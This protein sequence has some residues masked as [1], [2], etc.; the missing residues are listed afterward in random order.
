METDRYLASYLRQV[1]FMRNLPSAY[2]LELAKICTPRH[3]AV[4]EVIIAQGSITDRFF[5]VDEGRVHF[6]RTDANKVWHSAGDAGPGQHF[7][8]AMFTTQALA[9]YKAS[10]L[11]PSTLYVMERHD[12]DGLVAARPDILAA[13]GPIYHK[14]LE[15][16]RGFPW[17]TPGEEVVLTTHRHWFALVE[18]IAGPVLAA[19]LLTGILTIV[20]FLGFVGL[21]NSYPLIVG[22]PAVALVIWLAYGANDYANDDFIVT[23]KRVAHVE[24]IFLKKELRY[25]IPNDKIQSM[26]VRRV[27]AVASA[28]GISDLEVQS[29]G[30][31]DSRIVF[32]R[33]A[34]AEEI[35]QRILDQKG[36]LR[37][38]DEAEMRRRFRDRVE[39]DLAPYIYKAESEEAPPEPPKE[40][41]RRSWGSYL[42]GTWRRMFG[43]EFREGSTITYRKHW[44]AL[45]RQAAQ[46]ILLFLILSTLLILYLV[47][48]VLQILP[49]LPALAVGAFLFLIDLAGLVWQWEDWRNDIYQVT[50]SQ[51][52]DVE[53][54]PFGL[55]SRS[56][57]ALISN[58]QNARALRP[59][60]IN[61]ILNFGN[62]EVQTA[63]G[64]PGLV[65]Y[66]V[67]SPEVIVEELFRRIEYHRLRMMEHQMQ[68]LGQQVTDALVTYD[69]MKERQKGSGAGAS[70]MSL[71]EGISGTQ[72]A[73][74]PGNL[75]AVGND[76]V[77]SR[78]LTSGPPD[79]RGV[80]GAVT[81]EF[82]FIEE[83]EEPD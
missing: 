5:V 2:R 64:G 25:Q 30:R 17:L 78:Q 35:R 59:H 22:I 68:V 24:R 76:Q 79:S 18:A 34:R 48:P 43:R 82:S 71:T 55:R 52:I 47:F 39:R 51:I 16:T 15:L 60:P 81:Q 50:N 61:T 14:R 40:R 73:L 63:S 58:I 21:L 29:A 46:W 66:D 19:V 20:T 36:N 38:H 10:A 53:R 83:G 27:G 28:L 9:E 62:V 80:R 31:A 4:G 74:S 70:T 67:E 45:V 49:R 8:L 33:V 72:R 1:P 37:A 11:T 32:D 77:D 75:P 13:M 23:N 57:E 44:V 56:T 69:H 12:F 6:R 54:L 26:T 3:Y 41:P 7:G 65:F 42:V